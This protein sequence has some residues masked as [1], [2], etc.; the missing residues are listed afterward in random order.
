M[1]RLLLAR[2]EKTDEEIAM[3]RNIPKALSGLLA[4]LFSVTASAGEIYKCKG[5]KGETIY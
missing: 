1:L 5:A 2:I 4:I 3:T